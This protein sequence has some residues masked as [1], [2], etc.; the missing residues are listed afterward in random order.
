M[1]KKKPTVITNPPKRHNP[2]DP[3]VEK[4]MG[5]VRETI[6]RYIDW[7]SDAFTDIYNKAYGAVYAVFYMRE[8][9]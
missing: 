4:L 6:G 7:P 8:S 3:R 9:K 1:S 5:P 2:G